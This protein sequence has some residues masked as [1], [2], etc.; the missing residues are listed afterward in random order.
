M[1]IKFL[2]LVP[3]LLIIL[4]AL[5]SVTLMEAKQIKGK[6]QE[7]LEQG[8]KYIKLGNTYREAKDSDKALKYLEIGEKIIKK[9]NNKYWL[10]ST[11]EYYGY[12]FRDMGAMQEAINYFDMAVNTFKY[13]IHQKDGSNTAVAS[14]K[15][16]LLNKEIDKMKDGDE[17]KSNRGV[18][19][20]TKVDK[21]GN[22]VSELKR[23]KV[24]IDLKQ[25]MKEPE[26]VFILDLSN[27]DLTSFPSQV[28][29]MTNLMRLNLSGNDIKNIPE[30][31]F[32]GIP[33]LADLNLERNNDLAKLP[34][35][36]LELKN[37]KYLNLRKTGLSKQELVDLSKILYHTVI[38]TD[39]PEE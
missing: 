30:D 22:R 16:D 1:K 5:E 37:L 34:L 11:Y 27:R 6:Q 13:V 32:S 14:I 25:A 17:D 15:I 10:A 24:F 28:K 4:L 21:K 19:L 35:D 33:N 36:L 2:N 38:F 3:C 20:T 9:Y 23:Y 29:D 18:I 8:I 39:K 26:N 31:I 7:S 12:L